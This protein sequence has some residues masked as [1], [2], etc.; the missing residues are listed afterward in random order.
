MWVENLLSDVVSWSAADSYKSNLDLGALDLAALDLA[1]EV[2]FYV[3]V[4]D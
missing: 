3:N 4:S 2:I 1:D